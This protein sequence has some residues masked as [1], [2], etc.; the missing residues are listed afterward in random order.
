MLQSSLQL[1]G[2][3]G[4]SGSA[5]W[6]RIGKGEKSSDR[7]FRYGAMVTMYRFWESG[8]PK[9]ASACTRMLTRNHPGHAMQKNRNLL[10]QREEL[11]FYLPIF[12]HYSCSCHCQWSWIDPPI[13]ARI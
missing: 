10:H 6:I 9:S 3:L 4:V 11:L 13:G 5:F 8:I 7:R 12:S 2:L 1:I